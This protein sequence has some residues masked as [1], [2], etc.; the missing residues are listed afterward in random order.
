MFIEIQK[1]MSHSTR[2]R[3]V[4]YLSQGNATFSELQKYTEI[5]DHGKFGFHLRALRTVGIVE[6]DTSTMKYALTEHGWI[7]V[8]LSSI[9]KGI[10]ERKQVKER[11]TLLSRIIEQTSEPVAI[12]DLKG[13]YIYL[14]EA[15]EKLRGYTREELMNRD[16]RET[17][18]DT[19]REL[20]AKVFKEVV[21]SDF[22]T[23]ELPY[24]HKS[25]SIVLAMVTSVLLKDRK[26]E[27]YAI[28]GTIRDITE[29][30]RMEEENKNYSERLKKMVE[31]KTE[32]LLQ[33]ERKYKVLYDTIKDGIAA[34][35][36]D[37]FYVE[38]NQAFS[39]LLGYSKDDLKN[40]TYQQITPKRWH[41]R[42]AAIVKAQIMKRGYSNEYEKEYI[43]KDGTVFPVSIRAWM[44]EREN[45]KTKEMWAIIRD[46]TERK[47]MDEHLKKISEEWENTFNAI[48]D[49]LFILDEEYRIVRVNKAFCDLLKKEPRELISLHCFEVLH[50]TDK[51]WMNCPYKT[52]LTTKKETTEE[53]NDPHLGIPLLV[54]TSPLFDDKG[55]VAGCVH[56][57]RDITEQKRLEK[58]KHNPE[59]FEERGK[60]RTGKLK[61][62][63]GSPN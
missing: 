56:I 11:V 10:T 59:I 58:L 26:G 39:D 41:Q 33:S 21:K 46:I 42:E 3:I 40:L 38:C 53:I 5:K 24:T 36:T 12:V 23:G 1:V 7:V 61:E 30:K 55:E 25:G 17:Y 9:L 28:A 27:P 48:S 18:S 34:V 14:N 15:F 60:A 45:G 57:A 49:F 29:H 6:H 8:G 50:G 47:K 31:E 37:G 16:F 62:R 43:R 22:W 63:K 54:T 44:M 35:D 52:L 20:K 2:I 19:E 51:P 32:E 13:R 4:N